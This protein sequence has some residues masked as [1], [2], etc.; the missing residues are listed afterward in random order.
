[1]RI[2]LISLPG[3]I[4]RRA[5][6][7]EQF[8]T[9]G[10]EFEFFDGINGSTAKDP[11][12]EEVD[13]HQYLLNAGRPP[14]AGEIGC[15]ASHRA[16]WQYC[17]ELNEPL[18]V[19]EDDAKIGA[20]FTAAVSAVNG[21]IGKFSFIRLQNLRDSPKVKVC[22]SGIF[23]LYY[24]KKYPHGATGYAINP[25]AASALVANS[26]ILTAPADKFIK[27]FWQ[28]GQAMYCLLPDSITPGLLNENST[29]AGREKPKA[30]LGLSLQRSLF[31]I[32]CAFR[33][34]L[35]NWRHQP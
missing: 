16:V 24:C 25:T 34:T 20:N 17:V 22:D 15:H 33:R 8:A 18:I 4:E 35:F 28:H 21:L 1:M 6:A 12:F 2:V 3:S 13:H 23:T 7:I 30:R 11:L 9:A 26:R 27:N 5:A 19:L 14:S 32:H 31:K 10:L 29:I